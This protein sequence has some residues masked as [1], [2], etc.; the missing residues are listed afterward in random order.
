MLNIF[1]LLHIPGANVDAHSLYAHLADDDFRDLVN[2]IPPG[3]TFTFISDSCHSG[4]LIDEEKVQIGDAPGSGV[5]LLSG[6]HGGGGGGGGGS[7]GLMGLVSQGLQAY[8]GK[9]SGGGGHG[10]MMDL[11]SQGLSALGNRDMRT[12]DFEVSSQDRGYEGE[13]KKHH[14]HKDHDERKHHEH[15][16]HEER[17]H[18]GDEE[19]SEGRRGRPYGEEQYEGVSLRF[20][21]CA[22]TYVFICIPIIV[23]KS[24]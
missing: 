7:G 18:H 14:G 4:G 17:R 21:T 3:A 5:S 11:V 23:D 20:N 9:S 12:R 1:Y 24:G 13:G 2:K 15:R 6:G 8:A 19:W 22:F 16:D 10:G